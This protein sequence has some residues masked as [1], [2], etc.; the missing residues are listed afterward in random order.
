MKFVG[1]LLLGTAVAAAVGM[2]MPVL[3]DTPSPGD[4]SSYGR[5]AGGARHSPLTQINPT[6]VATLQKVW[7]YHM[8]GDD[9]GSAPPP[10]A[11]HP[12]DAPRQTSRFFPSQATPLVVDSVMYV[13]TPYGFVVALDAETG[14]E[15]WS[16]A[17]PDNDRPATRGVEYWPGSKGAKPEIVFGTRRGKLI[18]LDAGTGTPVAGFGTNGIVEM[19][20][21]AV[22]N[23]M[24]YDEA[25][26]GMSSPPLIVGDLVITGSRV[27]EAPIKGPSGD[28]RAWNA[29]T[30]KL[31]WTFHTIPQPGEPGHETWGGDSWKGRSGV[32]AWT[33]PV[34]DVDRGI[35]YLPIGA[36]TYDRW[37][38]DR[39]GANLY[40]NSIV[41]VEAR[42]GKYLWHFQTAHH[43]IWDVDAPTAS[44]V[45][46]TRDGKKIPAIAAMNKTAI[47]FLLDRVTGKPIYDVT[48]VPVPT[49]TDVPNE[50]V[51]PTQPMPAAPPPLTRL[52]FAM[53]ELN[54]LTP[55]AAAACSALVKEWNIVE[56]KAFQPLRTDSAV[57]FFPGSFGGVDWGG[58]TF[59]PDLGYFIV[60]TNSL[61]SPQQ[62]EQTADGTY[63][64]KGGY[65][66]FWDEKTRIPCQQPPWGE[67]V[68]VDVNKGTIAWRK[69]LGVSDSLP[70]G[71][72]NTGR[73]SLGGPITTASGVTFVG[74]TDDSRFRV[75]DSRT[76]EMLWEVKLPASIYATPITYQG[77]SGRQ[78]VAAVATGGVAGSVPTSDE[79]TAFALA[80]GNVAAQPII[81]RVDPAINAIIAPGTRLEKVADGFVFTEGPMWRD[82]WLW[83]SDLQGDTVYAVTPEGQKQVLIPHAGG[84]PNM[85]A[86]SN[87]G[88]NAMVP[89]KDGTVLMVQQ[90]GRAISRLGPDM[91]PKP[92]ITSYNG[93][94]INSPNDLVFA[95]DGSL[96]FTDPPFGLL[97]GD[98]D[99]AKEQTFNGVYRYANGK[100]SA[101]VTDLGL[102]NGIAIS[103]DGKTLYVNNYGPDMKLMAYD[104]RPD[105][106]VANGRALVTYTENEGVGGPDGL[107]ID[108]AGNLW[109]TGPGGIR[110]LSP[111]GKVLGFIR[112]PAQT[113]NLAFGE[114][115]KTVFITSSDTIYKLRSQVA[116]KMPMYSGGANAQPALRAPAPNARPVSTARAAASS[117]SNASKAPAKAA[118]ATRPASTTPAA[119]L[120]QTASL[121]A[122]VLVQQRCTGCHGIQQVTTQRKT[123]SAWADTVVDMMNKGTDLSPD[124]QAA[125]V[126]YLAE[127]YPAEAK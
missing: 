112:M 92:V 48:E 19:K 25:G 67:L 62:L 54:R 21:P 110:I 82:G 87:L 122:A 114:D 52:S 31:V 39:P 16:Y 18:A 5:D 44:L 68:A 53:S 23:G 74:G 90:G 121:D 58:G 119:P 57:A 3:A 111:Q 10:E 64:Q 75:F 9:A 36:P 7:T 40:S 125:V 127:H 71:L 61:A 14:Q 50:H 33:T 56:S 49:D 123:A 72:R 101:V 108:S 126:R 102:P 32:N 85:P 69:T 117:V 95:P 116:G 30:G 70:E 37:G 27:Q 12:S 103:Q 80:E 83:F 47:L 115:G 13:P 79:V 38:G 93:K 15:I 46:V 118:P 65:R 94:R 120:A 17:V 63:A 28:V 26:L 45:E 60:N 81:E 104:I 89:D 88:P 66:Y 84:Y 106:T 51:W 105:G 1:R 43:D 2:A 11:A 73:P 55:E 34:A 99:P 35:V 100:L 20:T 96:W 6:N 109:A 77:K 22:L 124:E 76:G 91:V 113:A 59:D 78:Y 8:R 42:T 4:W 24:N 41:A 86:G 29:R 107:K 98:D 97:K